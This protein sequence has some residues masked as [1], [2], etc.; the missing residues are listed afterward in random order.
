MCEG[1]KNMFKKRQPRKKALLVGLNK[2]H[3]SLKADLRGCVND[4]EHMRDILV[5]MFGFDPENIR[6]VIDD[7]ATFE[8]IL[9]RLYWLLEG[10]RRDDELVFHYSG[11]GS[12][13]RDRNGDELNDGLDEILC[14]TDSGDSLR[15]FC[16]FP[17]L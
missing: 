3:P 13:V 2:Y 17:I 7:R 6:V 4:V 11:H 10:S 14:P 1:I 9:E 15:I 8:G 12:Q 5:N 16:E